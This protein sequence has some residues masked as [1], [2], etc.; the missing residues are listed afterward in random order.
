IVA[1]YSLAW[2]AIPWA[3]MTLTGN[4]GY[5]EPERHEMIPYL[6]WFIEAY[7]Q[8]LLVFALAFAVPVL[9]KLAQARPFA[10]SIGLLAF[11]AAARFAVP[12]FVDLGSRQ[13]FAIYWVFHLA[14]FGWCAGLAD[15]PARKLLVTAF[16]TAVLGYLAFWESVWLGTTVKYLTIFAALSA[17]LY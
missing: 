17:L 16:A 7:A 11:A 10:F 3:S 13:I 1:A 4:F 6:Y 2:Q 14:V 9:R 8:T 15:T 5:A 12:L